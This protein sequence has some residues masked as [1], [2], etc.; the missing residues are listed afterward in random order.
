VVVRVDP[1]YYRPTEVETLLGDAGK[2][3]ERLGWRPSVTFDELV[4]DM[5]HADVE[6]AVRDDVLRAEGYV[7]R[8]PRE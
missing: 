2:A 3:H 6:N 1:R 7:I 5:V 4:Y 8:E